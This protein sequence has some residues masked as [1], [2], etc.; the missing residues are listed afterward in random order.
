MFDSA[1]PCDDLQIDSSDQVTLMPSGD[2][3]GISCINVTAPG[4]MTVIANLS[5][6]NCHGLGLIFAFDGSSLFSLTCL[7]N[8]TVFSP[9]NVL[10]F[11]F[12]KDS[13]PA[14]SQYQL[15]F[16]ASFHKRKYNSD[17]ILESGGRGKERPLIPHSQNMKGHLE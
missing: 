1:V 7:E 8:I 16:Q 3:G 6:I 4:E 13:Y 2:S 15:T 11:Y 9:Q 17:G 14:D 12:L 10:T 5:S